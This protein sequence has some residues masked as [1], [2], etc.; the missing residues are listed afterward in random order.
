MYP[1]FI[2]IGAQKAG[3]TW[4]HHNLGKHPQIWLPPVKEVHYL[5]H[6]PPG[7]TKRLFGRPSHLR[8]AR[9]Y[10]FKSLGTAVR[11]GSLTDLGWAARYWLAHR[12]DLWYQSLFPDLPGIVTGE[13]CPGY[14]RMNENAVRALHDKAPAARIIYL[15]RNPVDRAWSTTVM[16]FNKPKFGGI[17]KASDADI[18]AHIHD[19]RTHRHSDYRSNLANWERYYGER[20]HVGFFD[21]LVENPATFL[22]G[23]LEFLGMDASDVV[24]PQ[25]VRKRRNE[26]TMRRIPE[27]FLLPLTELYR[28]QIVDLD[29]KFANEHTARWRSSLDQL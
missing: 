2:C 29:A 1:D 19:Q 17:G 25:D 21:E 28:E 24:I 20:L 22:R 26:G 9:R 6:K 10:F 18:L 8:E 27:H 23:V 3:T 5:D 13:V 12:D 16:H 15:L 7:L 4:L 11:S 14:A